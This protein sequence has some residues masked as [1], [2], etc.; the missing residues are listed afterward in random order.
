M[1]T[2]LELRQRLDFA[3]AAKRAL[4]KL[5]D[6]EPMRGRPDGKA[7]WDDVVGYVAKALGTSTMLLATVERRTAQLAATVDLPEGTNWPTALAE[8]RR[9][10]DRAEDSA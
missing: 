4:V 1:S 6:L 5:L 10:H 2:G 8:V 9:L 7:T 3:E